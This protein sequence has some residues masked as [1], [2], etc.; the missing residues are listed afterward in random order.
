MVKPHM[1]LGLGPKKER[2]VDTGPAAL[3]QYRCENDLDPD[4]DDGDDLCAV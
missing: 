3:T 4:D 2:G 1:E